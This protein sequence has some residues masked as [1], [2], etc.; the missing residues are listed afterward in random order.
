[1]EKTNE[2]TKDTI[3]TDFSYPNELNIFRNTYEQLRETIFG[4]P[5]ISILLSSAAYIWLLILWTCY[6]MKKKS[7]ES[8]LY[9]IP[10]YI[11]LLI[12]IAGPCNGNYFRYLYPIAFC[13]P[14]VLT[15]GF[16]DLKTDF[17]KI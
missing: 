10:L 6:C 5:V 11:Q 7:V 14:S 3:H 2:L 16:K 15:L 17:E 12:C 1:M 9:I 13:L 4:F 8:I